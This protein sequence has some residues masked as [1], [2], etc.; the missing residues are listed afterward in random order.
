MA[1]Y[2]DFND[3]ESL[4]GL[5]KQAHGNARLRQMPIHKRGKARLEME[6]KKENEAEDFDDDAAEEDRIKR[7]DLV[8]QTRPGNAPLVTA[9]DFSPSALPKV[10]RKATSLSR[11]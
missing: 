8:E 2:I 11:T 7:V 1:L 6:S 10:V 3:L 9:E 5:I 4:H